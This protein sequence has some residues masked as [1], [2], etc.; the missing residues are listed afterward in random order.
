MATHPLFFE[1]LRIHLAGFGNLSLAILVVGGIIVRIPRPS[2]RPAAVKAISEPEVAKAVMAEA[3]LTEAISAK[4][5]S[6]KE[7]AVTERKTGSETARLESRT[8]EA[9]ARGHT[10]EG[11]AAAHVAG[12]TTAPAGKSMSATAHLGECRQKRDQKG[13]R[14]DGRKATHNYNYRPG[15]AGEL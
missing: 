2:P 13:E 15:S 8:G 12:G 5:I 6:A 7:D 10:A 3:L 4:T 1:V 9:A 14:R 11:V